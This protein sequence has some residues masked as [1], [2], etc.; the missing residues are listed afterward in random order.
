M[1]LEAF[2][3]PLRATELETTSCEARV[4]PDQ[5]RPRRR[6]PLPPPVRFAS[7]V[8]KD[9]VCRDAADAHA[10]VLRPVLSGHGV[11]A[12]A[13]DGD[14]ESALAVR[15]AMPGSVELGKA[16]IGTVLDDQLVRAS[17]V[18]LKGIC[19]ALPSLSTCL[20]SSGDLHLGDAEY[21]RAWMRAASARDRRLKIVLLFDDRDRSL[22]VP[23]PRSL[24]EIVAEL[25]P[26]AHDD[27]RDLTVT[28]EP[29]PVRGGFR[30]VAAPQSQLSLPTLENEALTLPDLVMLNASDELPEE[31]R[32]QEPR[33]QERSTPV[34]RPTMDSEL[35]TKK[36]ESAKPPVVAETLRPPS[37]PEPATEPMRPVVAQP[38]E[39]SADKILRMAEWRTLAMDLEAARGP[40]PVSAIERLFVQKYAPLVCAASRG[41][42]DA[43]MRMI[44]DEFRTNF[45]ESYTEA[46]ASMK[47]TGKRPTMVFDA[48]EVA[49]KVSR[50]SSARS[51]KLVLVD[52][53]SFELGERVSE[54]MGAMMDKRAVLV[55][56][57][58]LWSA[59]PTSTPTQMGLLSRG[60]DGLRDASPPPSEPDVSRG[61]NLSMLRRDRVGNREIL[62]LDLVEA[63]LRQPGASYDERL[64]TIA[65]EVADILVRAMETLPPRTLLYV[66][67]D[68]G[69]V[70]PPGQNGY[71]TGAAMQGGA[72]PEEVLVP[73]HA[74]LVDAVQ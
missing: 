59:L 33:S 17:L 39:P 68:H 54:R 48:F 62:K 53:M 63:R 5:A 7:L 71:A 27:E 22:L 8:E 24:G 1:T 40:K 74:W 26:N 50:L 6:R 49:A 11:L 4:E 13:I 65:D 51:T 32:S 20:D 18:P 61:R 10:L 38:E 43:T 16:P 73:G 55:E 34:K 66:F 14:F 56:K 69:F 52:A 70:M 25:Q 3:A 35:R 46:F 12:R 28:P 19:L 41:E 45:A 31:S 72:S 37:M 44:M 47:V 2:V 60:I 29:S 67:G 36:A 23:V 15:G 9:R 58:L 30:A 21:L 64:D 42:T 57:T